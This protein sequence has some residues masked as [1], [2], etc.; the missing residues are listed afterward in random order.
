MKGRH[1]AARYGVL[2]ALILVI[3]CGGTPNRFE[4]HAPEAIS[5]ELSLAGQTS[6]LERRGNSF[7]G[8]RDIY[9]DGHGNIIV[10]FGKQPPVKCMVGYVTRGMA[11]DFKFRIEGGK[12]IALVRPAGPN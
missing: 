11:L 9:G 2:L 5:A 7:M 4:V 12:C 1:L 3:G 8:T 10:H 6:S